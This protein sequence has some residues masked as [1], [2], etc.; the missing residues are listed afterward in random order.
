MPPQETELHTNLRVVFH[1]LLRPMGTSVC[2][3]TPLRYDATDARGAEHAAMY[4]LQGRMH[5]WY[6][7][8]DALQ[9]AGTLCESRAGATWLAMRTG[10]DGAPP[11][12]VVVSNS[13]GHTRLPA[14]ALRSLCGEPNYL[15][16][17]SAFRRFFEL[18]AD[19][20]P[21]ARY[22]YYYI[23]RTGSRKPSRTM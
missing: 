17:T 1:E 21:A 8:F 4:D 2:L 10:T 15:A 6:T 23:V 11:V 19:G 12:A 13:F 5:Q 7:S 18:V 22:Q 9:E 14:D 16:V 20:D 3:S